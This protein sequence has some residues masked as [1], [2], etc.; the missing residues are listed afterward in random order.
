MVIY[1]CYFK[2]WRRR[3]HILNLKDRADLTNGFRYVKELLLNHHNY[4]IY[5]DHKKLT[6]AG[7]KVFSVKTDAFTINKS[8]LD[9]AK[10]LISFDK[11]IGSWRVSKGEHI[12]FPRDDYH[13]TNNKEIKIENPKLN[14]IN[15]VD[16]YDTQTICKQI[17]EN[18]RVMIRAALPGSGKS[19]ICEYFEKLKYKTLMVAPT[20]VLVQKYKNSI[21]L[22]KFFGFGINDEKSFNKFD[23]SEYDVIA[24]DEIYFSSIH[25]LRKILKYCNDNPDK[26]IIATGDTDQLKPISDYS[27]V[28]DYK[29]YAGDI[30]DFIFPNEIYLFE[31]KR[32]KSKEDREKLKQIKKDIFDINIP[33]EQIIEKT[34]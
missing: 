27:N 11:G 34:L 21:T 28:K 33:V 24:F 22:N 10:T 9:L 12:N 31:N 18:K 8:D 2:E 23:D 3:D 19:Y 20:N 17:L 25:T 5:S 32:L 14:K 4:K 29:I 26:I 1:Y 6:K 16:E 15:I 7:I 13:I 30:I